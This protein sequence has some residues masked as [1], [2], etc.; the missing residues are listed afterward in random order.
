MII[1]FLILIGIA[2][3]YAY[4]LRKVNEFKKTKEFLIFFI[5]KYMVDNPFDGQFTELLEEL[6][7]N[8]KDLASQQRRLRWILLKLEM[9]DENELRR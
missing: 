6:K 3:L 4:Y 7:K 8:P 2:I 5:E 1:I 9:R